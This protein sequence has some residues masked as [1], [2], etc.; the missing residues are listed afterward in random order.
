MNFFDSDAFDHKGN[1]ADRT[2]TGGWL[3]A[4]QILGKIFHC[5]L[6]CIYI[7]IYIMYVFK[8]LEFSRMFLFESYSNLYSLEGTKT[9]ASNF[10]FYFKYFSL[11][12][13]YSQNRV[14]RFESQTSSLETLKL[15]SF[16]LL[17]HIY[18]LIA[19]FNY[20]EEL[21]K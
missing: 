16:I 13:F 14:E 9:G 15:L 1:P 11:L 8:L 4:A 17:L 5:L 21:L 19:T 7:Y 10:Y 12:I 2:K 20:R 3:S 18:K 6:L